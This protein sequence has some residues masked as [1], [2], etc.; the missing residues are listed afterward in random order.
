[1]QSWL[2]EEGLDEIAKIFKANNINGPEMNHMS[3]ETLVELGIG[4]DR[5]CLCTFR[6]HSEQNLNPI[7]E[8]H[9]RWLSCHQ[10]K[11]C[12]LK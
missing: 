5:V 6:N 2:R 3:K 9:H 12:S 8:V 7:N 4:E 10:Y 1:M 11:C